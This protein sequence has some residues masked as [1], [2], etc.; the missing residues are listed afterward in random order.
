[1]KNLYKKDIPGMQVREVIKPIPDRV[2][3]NAHIQLNLPL[4]VETRKKV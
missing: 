1:M 4:T 2:D 3:G